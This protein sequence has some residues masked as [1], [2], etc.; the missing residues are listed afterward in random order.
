MRAHQACHPGMSARF[1]G[2]PSLLPRHVW[3]ICRHYKLVTP[4]CLADLP[5]LQACYPG[6][7]ARFTGTPSL[8]PR[9]VCQIHGHTKLA[10]PACL[11]DLPALQ[12]CR[13]GMSGRLAGT[14]RWV[15]GHVWQIHG[16]GKMG[17]RPNLSVSW[18]HQDGFL[19]KTAGFPGTL[20]SF[21]ANSR[22]LAAKERWG[23]YL[24]DPC[25]PWRLKRIPCGGIGGASEF[26]VKARRGGETGVSSFRLDPFGIFVPFVV[27]LRC[28]LR[29]KREEC[30]RSLQTPGQLSTAEIGGDAE[31]DSRQGAKTQKSE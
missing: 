12:A 30:P 2:T 10:T 18:A 8:L 25:V 15:L 16:H 27:P 9:H 20:R 4:A 19:P 3:Q 29:M 7:S 21:P 11:P 14:P 5:A 23:R 1:T 6:M 13:P 24:C 31:R 22:F 26:R 17:A 28:S